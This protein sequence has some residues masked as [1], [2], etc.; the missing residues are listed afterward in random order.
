M[1]KFVY[2]TGFQDVMSGTSTIRETFLGYDGNDI[3]NFYD[4]P[5]PFFTRDFTDRFIGGNGNDLMQGL[6]VDL[7]DVAAAYTTYAGLSFHGGAGYDTVRY[8]VVG[9]LAN[10]VRTSVDLSR[11]QSLERSV[12]HHEF[13]VTLD[14]VEDLIPSATNADITGTNGDETLRL[15][16]TR[17]QVEETAQSVGITI[18][19]KG[20]ND[21]FEFNGQS[22]IAS[23]L[24]VNSGRGNDTV[25]IN[26][27]TT[28]YSNV[29]KSRIITG[30]GNDTVVLDGMYQEVVSVGAG[31]D[32]VYVLTGNFAHRPDV[33]D[34]GAGRD[35]VFLELDEYS[36]IARIR[37]FNATLDKIIFD[38]DELRDT[39]V[40]FD[41]TVWESSSTPKL[42]MDN[43]AGKLYFGDNVMATFDGTPTLTAA[44]FET[45]TWDFG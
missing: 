17:A 18:D 25:I 19:L 27:S 21:H 43:A 6:N 22:Q 36:T 29:D 9:T 24:N 23:T 40:T 5:K 28:S 41:K 13:R 20:G 45:D 31:A 37:D 34:T 35:K 38:E 39:N 15:T 33:I 7:K 32:E 44:N 42:Y 1:R 10:T 4:G 8:D 14:Y 16:L 3:F 2:G 30:Q 26:V 12:E 11:F